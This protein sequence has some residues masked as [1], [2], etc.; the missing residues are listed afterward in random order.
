MLDARRCQRAATDVTNESKG[1]NVQFKRI[2]T[3]EPEDAGDISTGMYPNLSAL[4][5]DHKHAGNW[6][7]SLLHW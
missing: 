2:T 1:E 5:L 4:N 6:D 7:G 3:R